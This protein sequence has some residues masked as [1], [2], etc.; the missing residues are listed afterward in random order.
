MAR[1]GMMR[2]LSQATKIVMG[3]PPVKLNELISGLP[4]STREHIA[5]QLDGLIQQAAFM[6][7]Y[8]DARYDAGGG[9]QGHEA[10]VKNA[11]K[12]LKAARRMLGYAYPK[13]GCI[14]F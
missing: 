1:Y 4:N 8:L 12:H 14:S 3:T 13:A 7:G 6:H 5:N 9:D 11:N 2:E 10:A